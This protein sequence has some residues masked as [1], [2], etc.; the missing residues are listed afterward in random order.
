[1]SDGWVFSESVLGPTHRLLRRLVYRRSDAF[2]G[3]SKKSLQLYRSYGVSSTHLFQSC[4]CV[5]NERFIH[6]AGNRDR[7]Y[8]LMYSGQI[9]ER[10]LPDFFVDV[11]QLVREVCG[12]VRVLVLG[13][14]KLRDRLLGR[15]ASVKAEVDYPGFVAQAV[16]PSHYSKAKILL[17]TTCMDPW[18]I[19]ANEALASG[20]PVITTPFAGA[21][22]ELVIDG[23]NGYV[24]D[25]DA[26]AWAQQAVNLLVDEHLLAGMSAN[27]V[28]S[29]A[30]FSFDNAA[31]GII[32]AAKWAFRHSVGAFK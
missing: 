2:I 15:L 30:E 7:P 28:N 12:R 4:L 14:G 25:T 18:G 6:Q 8:D 5:N 19:V 29:V 23:Q 10:K 9:V 22:G 32:E 1:M 31:R 26:A 17:F 13:D 11:V 27:A 16:L 20:T 21:A 3:A 24:I